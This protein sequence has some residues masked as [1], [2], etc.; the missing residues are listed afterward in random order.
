MKYLI[1][2]LLI[3][4]CGEN[5]TFNYNYD[6]TTLIDRIDKLEAK[7]ETL[8]SIVDTNIERIKLIDTLENDL[9]GVNNILDDL[10]LDVINLDIKD[11][12]FVIELQLLQSKINN[13]SQILEKTTEVIDLC[14]VGGEILIRTN[15]DRLISFFESGSKRYLSVLQDGAYITTDGENCHFTISNNQVI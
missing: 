5:T 12:N 11:D 2:S 14:Q 13:V 8:Q 15:D 6:D 1:I 10:K 4:S 7:N 9:K 3:I